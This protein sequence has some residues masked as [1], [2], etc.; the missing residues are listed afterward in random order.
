MLGALS[1]RDAAAP[2]HLLI[3]PPLPS[4]RGAGPLTS[5][6]SHRAPPHHPELVDGDPTPRADAPIA[7]P[8]GTSHNP[9]APSSSGGGRRPWASAGRAGAARRSRSMN[10]DD[11]SP[12]VFC[13]LAARPARLRYLLAHKRPRWP[14]LRPGGAIFAPPCGTEEIP[15]RFRSW[16]RTLPCRWCTPRQLINP[17]SGTTESVSGQSS[18][19]GCC[20]WVLEE[21][22]PNE[23]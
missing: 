9:P 20:P 12:G 1:G 11:V 15:R 8:R 16:D 23:R 18:P 3:L 4:S 19:R 13:G 14:G 5:P 22:A 17:A 6:V 10:P 2:A 21:G 7:P